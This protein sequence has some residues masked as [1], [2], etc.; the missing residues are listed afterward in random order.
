MTDWGGLECVVRSINPDET[1]KG[2]SLHPQS[3]LCRAL[4]TSRIHTD[5][6][7]IPFTDMT[8]TRTL[9]ILLRT[10]LIRQPS[11]STSTAVEL[12]VFPSSTFSNPVRPRAYSRSISN[13][14]VYTRQPSFVN[15]SPACGGIRA[16]QSRGY[17]SDKGRME[18]YSDEAGSTGA[19]TS[20]V[21]HSDAAFD[22]NKTNP[23]TAAKDVEQEVKRCQHP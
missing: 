9:G 16:T 10:P 17:A 3:T 21:A 1:R 5:A 12:S 11:A 23:K 15:A 4:A 7:A 2:L 19:G 14:P 13:T 8:F 22:G 18:L 6:S 20:D